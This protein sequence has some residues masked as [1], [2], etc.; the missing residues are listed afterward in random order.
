VAEF[1][2]LEAP[3]VGDFGAC[4]RVVADDLF[5]WLAQLLAVPA[6]QPTHIDVTGVAA[7]T[8]QERLVGRR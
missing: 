8:R 5:P 3:R 4:H 7:L 6:M 2:A 1:A